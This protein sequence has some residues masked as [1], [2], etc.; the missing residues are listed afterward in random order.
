MERI[1]TFS[2]L[3]TSKGNKHLITGIYVKLDTEFFSHFFNK[4]KMPTVANH[5]LVLLG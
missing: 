1:S 2:S 5:V 4:Y 3:I